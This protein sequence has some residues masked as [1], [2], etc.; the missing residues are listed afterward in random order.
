M[1]AIMGDHFNKVCQRVPAK[2]GR[3]MTIIRQVCC[4]KNPHVA[5]FALDALRQLA[6]RFL[7]KEEL[8][9]FKFQKDFLRPFEYTMVHNSNPDVRDMVCDSIRFKENTVSIVI[10]FAMPAT[11]DPSACSK[12]AIRLADHVWRILFCCQGSYWQVLSELVT[13]VFH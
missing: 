4:H 12:H 11:N 2:D 5:Y 9:H 6:I 3:G 10:G 8:P 1:W 7:E 13:T